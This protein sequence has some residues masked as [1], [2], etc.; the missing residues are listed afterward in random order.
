MKTTLDSQ[1]SACQ[2]VYVYESKCQISG[3]SCVYSLR[4]SSS[5]P[6][7]LTTTH[8][9]KTFKNWW[10][11]GFHY[12]SAHQPNKRYFNE[13]L[14]DLCDLNDFCEDAG[15]KEDGYPAL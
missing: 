11:D 7:L 13:I 14:N 8:H 10:Y 15:K 5:V 4:L 12:L 6:A 2:S 9:P 1:M 3:L